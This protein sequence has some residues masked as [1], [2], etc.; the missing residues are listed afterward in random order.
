MT[1]LASPAFAQ[2]DTSAA[3][4]EEIVVTATG[5]SAAIQDVPLAVTAVTSQQIENTGAN[6][7]RD[8]TQLA[9]SFNMGSGQSNTSGTIA[10][11]RGIG[12]GSD[13]PGFEGAVGIFIDGVY[14]ARAGAA[15]ADLPDLVRVEVLR[16]PQG[17]LFGRNTSAGAISVVT[18]GPGSD[19]SMGIEAGYGFDDLHQGNLRAMVNIPVNDSLAFRFDGA[20]RQRDGYIQDEISGRDI[21]GTDTWSGRAQ[22]LWDINPN[23]SLR[24][25]YDHSESSDECCGITPLI[26]G[27]T[28]GVISLLTGLPEPTIDPEGRSMRITPGR[29]YNE[30]SFEDGISAQLDWDLGFAQLTSITSQRHWRSDRDQDV[31]FTAADIAYRDGLKVGFN[32]FTQELRLQGESGN[33]NWLVGA[34]YGDEDLLTTDTIRIGS[35]ASPFT[36]FTTIGAT[37]ATGSPF[38]GVGGCELNNFTALNSIFQCA[39]GL[40]PGAVQPAMLAAVNSVNGGYLASN[41]S[42]QGQQADYWTVN[43]KNWSLFTHD[44]FSFTDNLVLTV[45]LR[46]NHEKKDL[47]GDLNA[48]GN[49]CASLQQMETATS[50][51]IGPQ[52]IVHFLDTVGGGAFSPLMNLACNPAVNTI[53]NGNWN[54][55]ASENEWTG[56]ASLAYHLDA[57]TMVYAG[58]SR[59]YKAGGFNVDRSG[60]SVLPETVSASDLNV[61]QLH[62]NPEFTDSYE[63]GFK[64]SPFGRGSTFNVT[65]FYEQIHDYQLNAFNGF[66]FLTKNVPEVISEG[67]ELESSIRPMAGLQLSGGLVYND[68]HYDSTV[69]FNTLDPVPNT[70]TSGEVLADAPKWVATA[71]ISYEVPFAGNMHA[72]F[73]L[74]GRWNSE[75]RTQTLQREPNGATDNSAYAVFNGRVALGPD[76]DH[77]SVELW[78]RNLTDQFYYVGAFSPP[79]QN[80]YVIFPSEPRTYGVTLKARW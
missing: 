40:L 31:D 69:V 20:I 5:R 11:V 16:G 4:T 18:A 35:Q 34:F 33:L 21:N 78:V 13:N 19:P 64:S 48:T 60:F 55:D 38:A 9:P 58:Y 76:T 66:N 45:G 46:Y 43:T 51:I 2:D 68:A 17:T 53:S 62:F 65:A 59:G 8:L 74:D 52:G 14:R 63:A 44:E 41:V 70:I 37:A 26:N 57:S 3:P 36:S 73:Y 75:Y 49:E 22:A 56:T 67:V 15:L 42:G 54:G 32:N 71:G 61:G 10:H 72:L 77:W 28:Q 7:L 12:T 39:V 23:A 47:F 1:G 29:D 30:T 50:G 6:D 25:I 27:S 80:D 79:L 24:V